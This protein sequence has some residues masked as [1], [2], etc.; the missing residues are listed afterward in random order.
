[1]EIMGFL[2]KELA[3]FT[4]FEMSKVFLELFSNLNIIGV[5]KIIASLKCAWVGIHNAWYLFLR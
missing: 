1:M 2:G 3:S 5:N 4:I